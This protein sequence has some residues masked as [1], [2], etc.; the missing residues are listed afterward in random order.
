MCALVTG[1]ADERRFGYTYEPETLPE[2]ALEFENW[3]T[4]RA[5]RS[6]SVGQENFNRWELRQELEYGV[7]DRY[8]VAF[9]L[10][11]RAQSYRN[12]ATGADTSAF[13]W[14]GVSLENRYNLLNPAEHAVGLTLYL[15]GRYSGEEAA[16]E[17]K[18]ILGQRSGAWKWALNLEHETEWE[19]QLRDVEGELGLSAGLARD[20]GNHWSLGVELRNQSLL[21]DYNAIENSALYLGPTLGFRQEKWWAVLSVQPQVYGWNQRS[22]SD[23][24]SHLE[25]KDHERVNI[26]FLTGFN[27]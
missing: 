15:E 5:G 10:N 8:T 18:L 9:Y 7:T 14:K 19:H 6:A 1:Q 23:G 20:L 11:E 25:L 26:R 22:R 17:Q 4:L 16:V 27:F 3:V 24:H 21:P 13:T 2:G 12:P